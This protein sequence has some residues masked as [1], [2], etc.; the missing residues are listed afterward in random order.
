MLS[1]L[2]I[3]CF[4]LSSLASCAKRGINEKDFKA[5]HSKEI[6]DFV[7][8]HVDYTD[9]S[10]KKQEGRIVIQLF[11]Q[12]APITVA[13]FQ[14]L[15]DS[16][17]YDGLTIHRTIKNTLIQGGDPKGNGTGNSTTIT[18]EFSSNNV[19]NPLSHVRGTVSM[20]RATDPNSASCQFFIMATDYTDF[21]GDYAAFGQVI[22]GM[23]VVDALSNSAVQYNKTTGELS[24][25]KSAIT[26]KEAYFVTVEDQYTVSPVLAQPKPQTP[27]TPSTPPSNVA[28]APKMED[29]DLSAID[30]TQYQSTDSATDLVRMSV[31][32]TDEN[33]APQTGS[34][35]IRLYADVAPK[36]VEN[37]QSLVTQGF[38]NGL[39]FHR[40]L[41]SNVSLLQGGDPNGDGTGSS[42]TTIKGEFECNG[43]VNNLSHVR[44]VISMARAT[45]Y[46]S[47][48]CQF[49]IMNSDYT[50]FDGDYAAF[51]YVVY[52]M[53]TVG[54]MAKTEL[55][56]NS[57]GEKSQPVNP[58]TIL[59]AEFLTQIPTTD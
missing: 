24:Y 56:V 19:D 52:G 57:R 45:A 25:P 9:E 12:Y 42:G 7:L 22:Y 16:D 38:Y 28:T 5:K 34:F 32:Y 36:T 43:F 40:I 11:P 1:I 35:V 8:L 3:A 33:G 15:V 39:T 37:F 29:L 2:L 44:G 31:S 26:I 51:G 55:T 41:A 17:F 49:F 13:N 50:A 20:A 6:T 30:L 14:N 23:E 21:D 58:V 46:N 53:E 10:G 54:E 18:G 47:A 27:P 48:S 59:S 4:V